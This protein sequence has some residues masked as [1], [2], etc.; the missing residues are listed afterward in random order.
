M[1]NDAGTLYM[2]FLFAKIV[3]FL[4]SQVYDSLIFT[5]CKTC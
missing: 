5:C 4:I 2:L 3:F 1:F